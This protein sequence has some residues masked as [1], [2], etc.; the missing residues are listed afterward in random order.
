MRYLEFTAP[1]LH[2]ES[3]ECLDARKEHSESM[4][5]SALDRGTTIAFLGSGI[6]AP[7]GYP[8]WRDLALGILEETVRHLGS[9]SNRSPGLDY[10]E[11]LQVGARKNLEALDANALMFLIG[12]C[13]ALLKKRGSLKVYS[14]YFSKQFAS[15]SATVAI[16]PF[17]ALLNLPIQRFATTNYD[18][19]VERA[20]VRYRSASPEDLGLVPSLEAASWR[21]SRLSFSQRPEGLAPL[22]RFSL[23]CMEDNERM[24]FHC[25]GRH[26]DPDAIVAT[27]ADYQRWYLGREDGASLAY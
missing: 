11:S 24:V 9:S 20:L 7:F 21:G 3:G 22:V 16:D 14:D 12:A 17:E 4:L 19:E 23:S 18:C 27:E 6:S 13:R 8:N 15:K 2:Y 1:M 10:I 25:H 5:L 26:D